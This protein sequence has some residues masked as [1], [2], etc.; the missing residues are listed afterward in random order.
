MVDTRRAAD[1]VDDDVCRQ[2]QMTSLRQL[3]LPAM[4]YLLISVQTSSGQHAQ[5][6]QLVDV[7]AAESHKLYQVIPKYQV[8]L[9]YQVIPKYQVIVKY[10]VIS[11]YRVIA[12]YWVIL[13][14]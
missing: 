4:C 1:D 6:L 8:I 2:Q 12:K 10:W 11:K 13:K 7:I 5:C 9:K 3:C 14:Y